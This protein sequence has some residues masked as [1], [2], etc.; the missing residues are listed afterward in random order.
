M[1]DVPGAV[2][3]VDGDRVVPSELARG[4]WSP[5]HQHGGAPSSLLARAVER[6]EPG[7]ADF[8]AR[9]TIDLIRPVPL[10]P[11]TVEARI[12]R[13]GKKIQIVEAVLRDGDTE[14]ALCRALR[15]RQLELDVD[16]ARVPVPDGVA[17]PEDATPLRLEFGRDQLGFWNAMELRVGRGRWLEPGPATVWFRLRVPVVE[18]EEPSPLQ[19]VAAA[20][21]FGNGISS[22]HDRARFSFINA[23]LHVFLH[24]LPVGEWVGLDATTFPEPEGIALA[25]AALLDA[26]GR[27]GRSLQSLLLDE[28]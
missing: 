12:R 14:V 18:G 20:A 8:V 19:R 25:E 4:P 16:V 22:A 1:T 10:T 23:D 15:M 3:E 2:F 26:G 28:L 27:I 17:A 11:L 7:P 21:D 13:P 9:L 6:C 24:R 5:L